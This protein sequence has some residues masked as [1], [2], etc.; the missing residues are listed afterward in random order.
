MKL[1]KV[2]QFAK[3]SLTELL[4]SKI[5]KSSFFVI[6]SKILASLFNLVFMIYS[7]NILSKSENG[8][9][10]YYLGFI[11][12][13]LSIAEFGLSSALIKFLSPVVDNQ[14]DIGIV[15]SSSLI[16]KFCSFLFLVFSGLGMFLLF[17]EDPL[18]IFILVV[19]GISMSFITFSESIFVSFRAYYSLAL[20]T[21]LTNLIRLAVLYVSDKYSNFP[22]N[23][24]DILSIFAIS[25]LFIY[26]LFFFIFKRQTLCW[27]AKFSEI[28]QEIKRLALFNFWAF[29]ASI[30]AIISD[31]LEIFFIKKYHS[32]EQ[33]A[34]YGTALQLF[35][36]FVII[37]ST[38]NSII[39]PGLSRLVNSPEFKKF[40]LKAVLFSMVVALAL[41][42]GYFL[43]ETILNFLFNEKY[44]ESIPVF[45]ILYPNYLLQLVFA[46]LGIALF[47]MG[48]PKILAILAFL[49][50]LFGLIL[51]NLLIPDFG[52]M[53]AGVSF[54]LGQVI[55]WLILGGYFWAIFWK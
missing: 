5:L 16:V 29:V 1:T 46:P 17:N 11:P 50:F 36:G 6:I 9:F 43:S 15:L 25:P 35:S 3:N 2:V 42:P 14:K 13:I 26:I 18:A 23:H 52:V 21:P 22:L 19:G 47:A 31:R 20:W 4:K 54:F 33:V 34:I 45:K 32:T 51:D 49:R 38:L 7:V 39:F 30:F 48:K 24:L 40:L 44:S 53:G 28:K 10:Q 27:N 8:V 37:L 12:V 55:S 41:S